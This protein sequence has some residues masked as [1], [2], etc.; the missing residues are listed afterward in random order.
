MKPKIFL[1]GPALDAVSGVATH[2]NQLF[3]SNLTRNF[4]LFH[5]Q[6]GGEG[7]REN[8]F[9]K[10]LRL[11]LSPISFFLM[12]LR[13]R[14]VIVHF[15]TSLVQKSYW[16]DLILL[17]ICRLYGCQTIYQIH[18]GELPENF[19]V[20][21]YILTHFLRWVL[22]KPDIIV[23]LALI[24]L[25]SYQRFVPGQ[26]LRVVANAIAIDSLMIEPLAAK[27]TDV[28]HLVFLGRLAENKG[29]FDIL[30]ALNILIQEGR[31][32]QLTIGG[33]GPDEIRF[34]KY[35][36]ALELDEYV[37]FS[38]AVFGAVKDQL[39]RDS[40]IFLFPTYHLEGLPYAILEAMAAGAVPITTR[41]GAIPD[42]MKDGVHGIL[43]E[44]KSA[45][46][47]AGAIARLDDNRLLLHLMAEASRSRIIER[48]TV[49]RLA[50]DFQLI[51][52]ALLLKD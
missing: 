28:L 46:S 15:N 52:D 18:G 21:N 34:R 9:R 24:E 16:R 13:H 27:S 47:L 39:W 4:D 5:F 22:M 43:I 42:V 48:Y 32:L 6:V 14:P 23:L 3:S 49:T 30:D 37:I 38:G 29:I 8:V 19:F 26:K 35:V 10:F 36:S 1:L 51:Y 11:T 17:L 20:G 25:D 45:V 50:E 12:L 31:N 7:R 40:N 44:A 2:L 41:V 33:C